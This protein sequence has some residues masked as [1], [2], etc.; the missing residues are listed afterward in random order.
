MQTTAPVLVRKTPT[1]P[2]LELPPETMDRLSAQEKEGL[3]IFQNS[4]RRYQHR[5]SWPLSQDLYKHGLQAFFE[6]HDIRYARV[7]L[8]S[9]DTVYYLFRD[10]DS[11]RLFMNYTAEHAT[12]ASS[13]N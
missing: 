12:P 10:F 5:V 4:A 3:E 1:P 6:D 11:L 9:V 8:S 2:V 13:I 7:P